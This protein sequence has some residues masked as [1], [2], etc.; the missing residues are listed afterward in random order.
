VKPSPGAATLSRLWE[1]QNNS[2]FWS[3]EPPFQSH[4]KEP[5]RPSLL[6][7]KATMPVSG[8]AREVRFETKKVR[9]MVKKVGDERGTG[10]NRF[11][12]FTQ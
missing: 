2:G 12:R 5:K 9:F 3:L 6:G 8:F 10:G 11:L 1:A 7:E 4:K